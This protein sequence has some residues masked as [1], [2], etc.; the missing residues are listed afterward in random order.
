MRLLS[1]LSWSSSVVFKEQLEP[2]AL[3]LHRSVQHS[4]ANYVGI[5]RGKKTNKKKN[6][7]V[8]TQHVLFKYNKVI[9]G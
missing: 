7:V 3:H 1:R 5:T 2:L 4:D 8:Q 9:I 6:S